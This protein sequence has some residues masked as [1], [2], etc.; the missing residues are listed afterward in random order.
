MTTS[1]KKSEFKKKKKA[2]SSD[3]K[4]KTFNSLDTN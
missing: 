4:G 2:V 3:T 1:D